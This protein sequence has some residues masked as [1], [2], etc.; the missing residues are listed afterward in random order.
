M[1]LQIEQADYVEKL[2]T[3]V[4]S[5]GDSVEILAVSNSLQNT[6]LLHIVEIP[7]YP[8][9]S[10]WTESIRLFNNKN[11]MNNCY[12]FETDILSL[13]TK[14]DFCPSALNQEYKAILMDPPFD[15]RDSPI[16]LQDETYQG[17]ITLQDFATLPIDKIIDDTQGAMLFI[18]VPSE[19]TIQISDICESWGFVL[20]DQATWI[21]RNLSNQ[22]V[23]H[24]SNLF[25]IS[26]R[27][28]LLFRKFCKIDDKNILN[29]L[30]LRPEKTCDSFFDFVRYHNETG[31]EL[32]PDAQYEMIEQLLPDLD[33]KDEGNALF[34][35]CPKNEKR[36]GWTCICDTKQL[37]ML[38]KNKPNDMDI[39]DW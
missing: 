35:W 3:D 20:V 24:D 13:K 32:K 21:M 25:G 37:E 16:T 18:W 36:E 5:D 38:K 17:N 8:I 4:D 11:K 14:N 26:K 12:Y 33:N 23:N 39:G 19:L 31:R 7:M 30:Q 34:L 15:L 9:S 6:S 22:I 27:N 10:S 2:V 28:L 29:E 1:Q